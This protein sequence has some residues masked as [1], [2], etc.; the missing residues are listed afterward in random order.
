MNNIKIFTTQKHR[1]GRKLNVSGVAFDVDAK[2]FAEVPE[3]KVARVLASGFELVDKNA[4]FTSIEEQAKA[5]DVRQIIEAAKA[6][7]AEII[8]TAQKEA[9]SIIAAARKE[10]GDIE[11][12]GLV[13][14]KAAKIEELKGMTNEE[15]KGLLAEAGVPEAEYAKMKKG[16]LIDKIISIIFAE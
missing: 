7:A 2:G 15:L 8:S 1:F 3:D 5:D 9:N 13:P 14:E 16:D 6:Q 12:E 11:E 4:K 10:A